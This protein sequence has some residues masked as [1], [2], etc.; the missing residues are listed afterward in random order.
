MPITGNTITVNTKIV[1]CLWANL[2]EFLFGH[3]LL[4]KPHYS[5]NAKTQDPDGTKTKR[6]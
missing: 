4:M 1:S 2:S 3:D 6:I 5:Y